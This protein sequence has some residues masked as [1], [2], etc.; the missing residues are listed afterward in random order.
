MYG[1][2]SGQE[3]STPV[4]SARQVNW[5]SPSSGDFARWSAGDSNY[6]NPLF[7]Y[8]SLL[9]A[10]ITDQALNVVI[11]FNGGSGYTAG[12]T[13]T[14]FLIR[15]STSEGSPNIPQFQGNVTGNTSTIDLAGL[16]TT[17]TI[18]TLSSGAATFDILPLI[19]ANGPDSTNTI[20]WTDSDRTGT[21][22]TTITFRCLD[23][24]GE[25]RNFKLEIGESSE[26]P[27]VG[28][29]VIQP[30]ITVT[31]STTQGGVSSVGTNSP[32]SGNTLFTPA[33]PM[34]HSGG[35]P[36][37]D[38]IIT[39]A[40]AFDNLTYLYSTYSG[41]INS[42][43]EFVLIVT[44]IG[45]S[46]FEWNPELSDPTQLVVSD[47]NPNI[48]LANPPSTTSYNLNTFIGTAIGGLPAQGLITLP[49]PETA[50]TFALQIRTS[51]T[52]DI[53]NRPADVKADIPISNLIVS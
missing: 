3:A 45:G 37:D 40:F 26:I 44:P 25:E 49:D 2:C 4:P 34:T 48:P 51:N 53:Y 31:I 19:I 12:N 29:S 32:L 18:P 22:K 38:Y 17:M 16:G 23:D 28:P 8:N 36:I 30:S 6:N 15:F 50:N 47:Y 10:E 20:G 21:F 52:K 5:Q 42:L 24:T 1:T 13:I 46:N 41:D 33:I 7:S 27:Q 39:V 43:G 11:D 14:S 9:T 35:A